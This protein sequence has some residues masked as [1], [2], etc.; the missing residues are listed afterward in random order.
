MSWLW[1]WEGWGG[2]QQ[3][4]GAALAPLSL[5]RCVGGSEGQRFAQLLS[6]PVYSSSF[7]D[8]MSSW[9]PEVPGMN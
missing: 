2:W 4:L 3:A 8:T 9:S 5:Q 6:I 1:K 7:N